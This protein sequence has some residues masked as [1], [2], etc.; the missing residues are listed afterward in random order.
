VVP[1]DCD[2]TNAEAPAPL[3]P[4]AGGQVLSLEDALSQRRQQ[5]RLDDLQ[6]QLLEAE[7]ERDRMQEL[8]HTISSV[9]EQAF[10]QRL[11]PLLQRR[12]ELLGERQLLQLALQGDQ[13]AGGPSQPRIPAPG[14][15]SN[16]DPGPGP[17][18]EEPDSEPIRPP[19]TL[20]M[21][22]ARGQRREL[23]LVI[24]TVLLGA[25][26]GLPLALRRPSPAVSSTTPA[27][28]QPGPAEAVANRPPAAKT[29]PRGSELR[30]RSVGGPSW[31]EV[32]DLQNRTV[33][34]GT[35][36][37]VR[38]FPLGQG[39]RLAAGRPDLI[40]VRV[41]Q[42]TERVLGRVEEIGWQR[43]RPAQP[44]PES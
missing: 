5:D 10:R 29:S 42:G 13:G 11:E 22:I 28:A 4:Q 38:R 36:R 37:G 24:A 8:L 40:R 27:P 32:R 35:L 16:P 23:G 2:P 14:A 17:A 3:L 7:A 43:I 39:L 6:R 26:L 9:H 44:Q 25:A 21:A 18:E 20:V 30:L 12:R 33:W 15:A 31:L 41:N 34:I 1:Q 19:G